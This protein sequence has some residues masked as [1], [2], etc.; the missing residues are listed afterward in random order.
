MLQKD[1][2]RKEHAEGACHNNL[3]TIRESFLKVPL[4]TSY[5]LQMCVLL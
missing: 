4:S 3:N 2:K 5:M 1:V